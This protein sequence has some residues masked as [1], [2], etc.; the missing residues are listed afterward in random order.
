MT[1]II[2]LTP[3][4]KKQAT[5]LYFFASYKYLQGLH[6]RVHQLQ[7]FADGILDKSRSEGRDRFLHDGRWGD[8]DKSENWETNAY[9][10]LRNF[11]L[12]TIRAIADRHS[13]IFRITGANQCARGMAEFSM[14]WTTIEEQEK[15]DNL[16]EAVVH[17]AR[18]IDNTVDKSYRAGRWN[19]FRLMMAWREHSSLFTHIPVLRI[20]ENTI[21]ET[22]KIPQKTGVYISTDHPE[23]TLQFAWNGDGYGQLRECAIF[24]QLGREALAQVGREGLWLDGEA[25]L[26]FVQ[27]NLSSRE[28]LDDSFFA[29]SQTPEL[30][31]SLVGRNAF[32]SAPSKWCYVELVEGEFEQLD[33]DPNQLTSTEKR[34]ESGDRCK[35]NGFYFTPASLDSRRYFK[36]GEHSQD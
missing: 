19:D 4:Q 36:A 10:F 29:D 12:S 33:A 9:S 32:T 35:I 23:G 5:L 26:G 24:N 17:Y 3:W 25:M 20:Q 11:G 1:S 34:Y 7:D 15:F 2:T 18:F 13:Q 14:Q 27:K 6:E 21:C 16:L 30:A 28:L 8:R 31:P 22:G